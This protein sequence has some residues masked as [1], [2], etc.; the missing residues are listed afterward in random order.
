MSNQI[1][2]GKTTLWIS[3]ITFFMMQMAGYLC[4]LLIVIFWVYLCFFSV[5]VTSAVQLIFFSYKY[6][7]SLKVRWMNLLRYIAME[8][9]CI[10]FCFLE[11]K[12]RSKQQGGEEGRR[13]VLQI[14]NEFLFR[15]VMWR[16]HLFLTLPF[17]TPALIF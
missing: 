8:L 11:E 3:V 6:L 15:E 16:M 1:E 13:I 10:D 4:S 17:T 12:R 5:L 2:R 9:D 14:R 7:G